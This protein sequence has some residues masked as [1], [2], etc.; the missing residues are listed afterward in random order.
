MCRDE[1]GAEY[2]KSVEI[3]PEGIYKV[4]RLTDAI[5][6]YYL[7]AQQREPE[8]SGSLRLDRHSR[9]DING[10][11]PSREAVLRRRRLASGEGRSVRCFRTQQRKRQTWLDLPVS[12][13]EEVGDGRRTA[14]P[15]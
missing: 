13:I 14:A 2:I 8:P 9:R 10:R 11:S 1:R 6:H 7:A 12:G 15:D 3:S 4:E 5:E